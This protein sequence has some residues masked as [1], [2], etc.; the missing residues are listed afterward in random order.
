MSL[1][2]TKARNLHDFTV[3]A[4]KFGGGGIMVW[5]CI[6]GAGLGFL[7]PVNRNLNVSA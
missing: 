2:L 7:A 5:G 1:G 6:W 4:M 3:A